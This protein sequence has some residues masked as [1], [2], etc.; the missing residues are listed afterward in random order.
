MNDDL[1]DSESFQK[2]KSI[3]TYLID[4]FKATGL[5]DLFKTELLIAFEKLLRQSVRTK[6]KTEI[7]LILSQIWIND[8]KL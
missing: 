3:I 7:N 2:L 5:I 4:L 1:L 8:S 6:I